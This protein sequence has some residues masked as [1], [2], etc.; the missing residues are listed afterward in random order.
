MSKNRICYVSAK[1]AKRIRLVNERHLEIASKGAKCLNKLR[2]DH[3]EC[4]SLSEANLR[5]ADLSH[6]VLSSATFHMPDSLES[7]NKS[8]IILQRSLTKDEEH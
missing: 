5:H 3:N 2:L 8:L 6:A 7:L 4:P 1:Q